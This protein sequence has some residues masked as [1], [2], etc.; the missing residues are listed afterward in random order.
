MDPAFPAW[1]PDGSIVPSLCILLVPNP[2]VNPCP[3]HLSSVIPTVPLCLD[4]PLLTIPRELGSFL[5]F[6]WFKSVET[7]LQGGP[8]AGPPRPVRGWA[9]AC[10][11]KCE[12]HTVGPPVEAGEA[13]HSSAGCGRCS[14]VSIRSVKVDRHP[15]C[16]E[17]RAG[18]AEVHPGSCGLHTGNRGGAPPAPIRRGMKCC[19]EAR[20][21][22]S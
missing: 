13:G 2:A 5:D 15:P 17:H 9:C 18:A 10:L 3:G 19:G 1:A 16:S 7:T 4:V 21:L 11:G 22:D 12:G 6:L 20:G 14:K 8:E